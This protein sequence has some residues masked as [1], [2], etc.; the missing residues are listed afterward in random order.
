MAAVQL[1]KYLRFATPPSGAE[2]RLMLKGS[3]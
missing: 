3:P 1:V 2:A